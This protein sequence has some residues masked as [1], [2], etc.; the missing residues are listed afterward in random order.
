M[1]TVLINSLLYGRFQL[2]PILLEGFLVAVGR[3]VR[4]LGFGVIL[5]LAHVILGGCQAPE[6]T[7]VVSILNI[8]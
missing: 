8:D 1:D 6:Q 3:S 5:H 7:S 2:V 4:T